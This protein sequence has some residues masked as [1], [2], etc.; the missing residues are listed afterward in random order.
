M[1]A[2][3][4]QTNPRDEGIVV[5]NHCNSMYRA[6]QA[7]KP[8]ANCGGQV[9][10]PHPPIDLARKPRFLGVMGFLHPLGKASDHLYREQG[11]M[12]EAGG[13]SLAERI[14]GPVMCGWCRALHQ[15][16][17]QSANCP[18]CG[19]VLP[20]PPGADPGP[21]PPPPPRS[22]PPNFRFHL[23]IKQNIGGIVGGI[24][25][26]VSLPFLLW[27]I[28]SFL[29]GLLIAWYNFGTAHR[30]Q[31]ALQHGVPVPGRIESVVQF[32]EK[33][34]GHGSILYRVYYRFDT[35]NNSYLGLKWTYD[36]A[37]KNHFAGEPIWVVH[38]PRH[39]QYYAIWPP[40][41]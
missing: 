1:D 11:F 27:G 17:P 7:D 8:C 37:I 13:A 6:R 36:P 39:P 34:T 18:E 22:L 28:P 21:P 41:A 24:L 5:C 2:M 40:L 9:S 23:Y 12:Q 20:L 25:M 4:S 29:L 3:S 10:A 14:A 35:A 31:R 16:R 30:R 32:G 33:N 38:V 15:S 26:L 19:G